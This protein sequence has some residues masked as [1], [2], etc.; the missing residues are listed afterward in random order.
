MVIADFKL[1]P[2]QVELLIF[3]KYSSKLFLTSPSYINV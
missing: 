2:S 1:F 3:C